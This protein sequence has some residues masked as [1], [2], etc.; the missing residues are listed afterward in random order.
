MLTGFGIQSTFVWDSI[1]YVPKYEVLSKIREMEMLLHL[2]TFK[3]DDR[4]FGAANYL[5][6]LALN[7]NFTISAII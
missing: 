2:W 3:D 5:V 1:N 7:S 6:S 4:I